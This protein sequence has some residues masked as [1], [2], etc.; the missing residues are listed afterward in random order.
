MK[1]FVVSDEDESFAV[2]LMAASSTDVVQTRDIGQA[3]VVV[4]VDD[5]T[6]ELALNSSIGPFAYGDIYFR[7]VLGVKKPVMIIPSRDKMQSLIRR[8]DYAEEWSRNCV[9]RSLRKLPIVSE[10]DVRTKEFYESRIAIMKKSYDSAYAALLEGIKDSLK[11]S[12]KIISVDLETEGLDPHAGNIT[13][14]GL[15]FYSEGDVMGVSGDPKPMMELLKKLLSWDRITCIFHN[16]QFD[17]TWLMEHGFPDI[18]KYIDIADS[19][20]AARMIHNSDLSVGEI[21]DLGTL[22]EWY[23]GGNVKEFYQTQEVRSSFLTNASQSGLFDSEFRERIKSELLKYNAVDSVATLL[24][25]DRLMRTLDDE[26]LTDGYRFLCGYLPAVV[27][28]MFQGLHVDRDRINSLCKEWEN[29]EAE[30]LSD[31]FS[32]PDVIRFESETG[33]RFKPSSPQS[34]QKLFFEFLKLPYFDHA[35]K[36]VLEQVQ[37]EIAPKILAYRKIAKELGTYLNPYKTMASRLGKIYPKYTVGAVATCRL[38]SEKPNIQNVVRGSEIRS[39]II[40]PEGY[41]LVSCD[42]KQLE[43]TIIACLSKDDTLIHQINNGEDM[44]KK[45]AIRISEAFPWLLDPWLTTPENLENEIGTAIKEFR[46][47]IKSSWSFALIYGAGKNTIGKH[48]GLLYVDEQGTI[49]I[50]DKSKKY[51]FSFEQL[52][53]L[54]DEYKDTYPKVFKWS[55]G[56][57]RQYQKSF[58]IDIGNGKFRYFPVRYSQ[59]KNSSVQAYGAD[60]V[61]YSMRRLYE[62]SLKENDSNFMPVMNIHDDLSFY[63]KTD[64]IKHYVPIIVEEMTRP[65][66]D[67]MEPLE[68]KVEVKHGKNWLDMDL[69]QKS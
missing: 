64:E 18:L 12:A 56:I 55:D 26:N 45:W 68:F 62:K 28:M 57:T 60:V 31:I 49:Q 43:A 11:D 40:A 46:Q 22:S 59:I 2:R 1:F 34:V 32:H 69:L 16:A 44:H 42:Y 52:E 63:I 15:A 33:A 24:L 65:V 20:I 54:V 21:N 61:N 67:W 41:S 10:E 13:C 3:D 9:R 7:E 37:H 51:G 35:D 5:K 29:R 8:E 25:H 50:S 36:E 30:C 48:L 4:V 58:R 38:S 27:Q 47:I 23:L 53:R 17:L 39:S 14:I 66:W 6:G 19:L